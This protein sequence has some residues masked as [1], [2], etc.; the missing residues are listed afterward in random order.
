MMTSL[1]TLVNALASFLIL[2]NTSLFL[3]VF[4]A[5]RGNLIKN[6][7]SIQQ[8]DVKI[9]SNYVIVSIK[10]IYL[11]V[12]ADHDIVL[13]NLKNEHI[14]SLQPTADP[15]HFSLTGHL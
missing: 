5:L 13:C 4:C 3:K 1:L 6:L 14:V 7:P 10:S 9:T 2:S 11:D 15:D 12:G 8:Y